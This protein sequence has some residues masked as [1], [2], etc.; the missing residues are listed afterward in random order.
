ML[1]RAAEALRPGGVLVY[2]TCTISRRE[3][4]GQVG[5]LLAA[6]GSGEVPGMSAD[7]LGRLVPEF[8]STHDPRCLQLL[9]DRDCT[10]GFSITRLR[11]HD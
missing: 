2:S 8:A 6:A 7:E 9:P 4:E 3:G 1:L 11:R 10:T 5:A